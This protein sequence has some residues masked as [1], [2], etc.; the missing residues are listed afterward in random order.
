MNRLLS[1]TLP[2]TLI[3]V[4]LTT[5]A[6]DAHAQEKFAAPSEAQV[7][8]YVK[9]IEA[10]DAD[11]FE[12][13]IDLLKSSLALGELNI[14]YLNLG[15]AYFKNGQC[16]EA[17]AAFAKVL[18][19]PKIAEPSPDT[20][21][22][23]LE[24]FRGDLS[25]CPGT[26]EVACSPGSLTVSIDGAAPVPCAEAPFLLPPGEHVLTG[27]AGEK[28]AEAR[29]QVE[30][31]KTH[32]V[33]L[34]ADPDPIA[35]PPPPP[36][37]G[38]STMSVTGLVIAGVGVAAMTTGII[39]DQTAL[40]SAIDDYS[41]AVENASEN[42]DALRNDAETL[43]SRVLLLYVGGGVAVAAGATLFALGV[44]TADDGSEPS[45]A[46]GGRISPWLTPDGGAGVGW[47]ASW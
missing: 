43:Q 26:V 13:A 21:A 45:A 42:E 24:E 19:S 20:I 16:D 38:M 4:V 7:Q 40:S 18:T 37:P 14:I 47:S 36:E 27:V 25:Q 9:A 35:P 10:I 44:Q 17:E 5:A 46:E 28:R 41:A 6:P 11:N 31:R 34:N 33:T 39:V 12:E 29:V 15:R 23:T 22:A 30:S 32:R 3:G 8:L 2:L 1:I